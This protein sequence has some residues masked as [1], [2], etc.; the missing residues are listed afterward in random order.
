M[1]IYNL[2]ARY[3]KPAKQKIITTLEELYKKLPEGE[4]TKAH[5]ELAGMYTYFLPPAPR[6]CKNLFD[7]V[8][9]ATGTE[10]ARPYLHYAYSDGENLVA[11]DGHRIHYIK[12]DLEVGFY[13]KLGHKI[14]S[15]LTFPDYKRVIPAVDDSQEFTLKI[16]DANLIKDEELSRVL[17]AY[18]FTLPSG[19]IIKVRKKYFD[20]IL[21]GAKELTCKCD[22]NR[23]LVIDGR[24]VLMLMNRW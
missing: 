14:E 12:T 5:K 13:D 20:D 18:E 3:N 23:C 17:W 16:K 1:D 24:A 15:D 21:N 9:K 7:W 6:V 8:F 10:D 11:T 4:V 19:D 22:S 2:A